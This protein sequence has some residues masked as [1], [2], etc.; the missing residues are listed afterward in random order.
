MEIQFQT[1]VVQTVTRM[2]KTNQL[3]TIWM[4]FLEEEAGDSGVVEEA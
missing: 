3:R 4:S 1:M 2:M